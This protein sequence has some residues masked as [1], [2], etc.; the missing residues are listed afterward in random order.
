MADFVT[1]FLFFV[2]A[3]LETDF[4]PFKIKREKLHNAVCCTSLIK[5]NYIQTLKLNCN[6]QMAD[7][8]VT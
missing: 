2:I 8:C 1:P 5:P 7:K 6:Y 3:F 4:F